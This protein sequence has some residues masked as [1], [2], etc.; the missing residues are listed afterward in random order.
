MAGA[1][2]RV[3]TIEAPITNPEPSTGTLR[4]DRFDRKHPP[5]HSAFVSPGG[6]P[7]ATRWRCSALSPGIL[8]QG[9]APRVPG[10]FQRLNLIPVLR[11]VLHSGWRG[12]PMD[13]GGPPNGGGA[14]LAKGGCSA[15]R[16]HQR[17]LQ[18]HKE[19]VTSWGP[20]RSPSSKHTTSQPSG[21]G[22]GGH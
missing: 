14:C 9:V 5:Q 1:K 21:G 20:F 15:Q 17:R 13:L 6:T 2:W 3:H 11:A 10:H 22:G 4:F 19:G 18:S 12:G 7:N 16:S 8:M